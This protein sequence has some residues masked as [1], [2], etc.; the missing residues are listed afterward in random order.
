MQGLPSCPVGTVSLNSMC[1]LAWALGWPDSWSDIILGVSVRVFWMRLIFKPV[2]GGK[3]TALPKVSGPHPIS[4][5][6][7]KADLPL[8]KREFFLPDRR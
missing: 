1:V 7:Q 3:Q 4:P 8:G 6:E 5:L 2:D